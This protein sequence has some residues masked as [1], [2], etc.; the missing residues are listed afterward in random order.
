MKNIVKTLSILNLIYP[1]LMIAAMVFLGHLPLH[2]QNTSLVNNV[3]VYV[4]TIVGMWN[5]GIPFTSLVALA[6]NLKV[7]W[8]PAFMINLPI[9]ILSS[10]LEITTLLS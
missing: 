3:D 2:T 6:L 5:T 9:L 10:F 1:F 7:R 4:E 8:Q